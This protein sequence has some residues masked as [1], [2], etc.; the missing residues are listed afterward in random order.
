[1]ETNLIP[2]PPRATDLTGQE[3]GRWRVLGIGSFRYNTLARGGKQ[4]IIM[5]R[6]LCTCG[7]VADI[8]ACSLQ[9]KTSLG[10]TRCQFGT[11]PTE[12]TCID[13]RETFPLT[14]EF[15]PIDNDP[16]RRA[17]FE[18]RCRPC[19]N[20][21]TGKAGKRMR[22]RHRDAVISH[23]GGACAC[24]GTTIKEFLAI[25]HIGGG[26]PEHRKSVG[27]G[28]VYA[29]LV[30][31]GFPPGFRVLCHCCNA[32]IGKYGYCPHR[33]DDP[34]FRHTAEKKKK[35]PKPIDPALDALTPTDK[36]C[37]RCGVSYPANQNYFYLQGGKLKA[38][39]RDCTIKAVA[40]ISSKNRIALRL[41]VLR[42]YGG[43]DPRCQCCGESHLEFLE[44]DH[45]NGGGRQD[46]K[47]NDNI[48][49]RLKRAGFP[50]GFRVLCSNCNFSRGRYSRCPHQ[51]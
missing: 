24:C 40:P 36:T 17:P 49:H 9:A 27:S 4:R 21:H 18:F 51:S 10:C 41:E 48:Y 25:D 29:D 34:N 15:F 37:S 3:I 13:C 23:Y 38:R 16:R 32:S 7:T 20:K 22:D 8:A 44:I 5:W 28:H 42:S 46:R 50:P 33:P 35:R 19:Y 11:V 39:C 6:C 12:R 1:M 30:R 47:K 26:G 14:A 2:V 45:I 31:R 43:Q